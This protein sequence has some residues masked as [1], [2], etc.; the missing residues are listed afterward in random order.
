M[1]HN[2][3]EPVGLLDCYLLISEGLQY[4]MTNVINKEAFDD[5]SPIR[6]KRD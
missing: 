3:K 5:R 4:A 1:T 6:P 2:R